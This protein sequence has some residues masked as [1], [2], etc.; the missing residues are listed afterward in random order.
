MVAKVMSDLTHESIH[1]VRF[2]RLCRRQ[3]VEKHAQVTQKDADNKEMSGCLPSNSGA[4]CA[5]SIVVAVQVEG[6][7]R[8]LEDKKGLV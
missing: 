3:Q 6:R 1:T 4:G 8:A 2:I 7:Q 5:V